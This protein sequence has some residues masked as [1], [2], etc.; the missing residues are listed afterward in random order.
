MLCCCVTN[1][2]VVSPKMKVLMVILCVVKVF[3]T[4]SFV[5]D[6]LAWK[7][8]SLGKSFLYMT[9]ATHVSKN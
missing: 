3:R 4:S 9:Q 2:E 1:S 8:L 7:G 6:A 5:K